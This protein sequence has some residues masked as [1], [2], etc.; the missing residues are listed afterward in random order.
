MGKLIDM[1]GQKCGRLTVIERSSTLRANKKAYWVCEC[2]CGNRVEVVGVDL[3]A[4][5][6][7]SCGCL[8]KERTSQTSKAQL[9]GQRFGRLLVLEEAG[10]TDN[11][12]VLW[13][14]K[15]DCGNETIVM[16]TSLLQGK[17]QSC[18][19][20]NKERISETSRKD[21]T[22]QRFGKLVAI[23]PTELRTKE[24]KVIWKCQCDCGAITTVAIDA[25]TGGRTKSC[26]CTKS[27]GEELIAK[28]L[29]LNQMNFKKEKTFDDCLSCINGAKL[30]FDFWVNEK[31]LIEYDGKQ[32]YDY[33]EGWNTEEKYLQTHLYDQIKN[34]YCFEHKIPLIRIPYTHLSKLCLEDLL[35][36]TSQFIIKKQED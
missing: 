23:E 25:L 29:T 1:V 35:L 20:Y 33:G 26:G 27:F 5:K 2:E 4:G 6:T 16:A 19:C 30:R 9:Q 11:Q 14:C 3:R 21:I 18:G 15:C 36:E 10:R 8:Q 22:G 32:H 28:L 13:K 12:N 7:Q 31:Y 24:Q 34:E 17:T